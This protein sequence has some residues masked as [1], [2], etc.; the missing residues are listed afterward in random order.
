MTLDDQQL[1]LISGWLDGQLTEAE[2]AEFLR[3]RSDDTGFQKAVDEFT[4]IRSTLASLSKAN[5]SLVRPREI[6]NEQ[7]A[8]N[9]VGL[10][11]QRVAQ[12][13][14]APA[15]IEPKSEQTATS[16]EHEV[17]TMKTVARRQKHPVRLA[18]TAFLAIAASLLMISSLR[19]FIDLG[20]D[21]NLV[22]QSSGA[23]G[24]PA[25]KTNSDLQPLL[26]ENQNGGAMET[27]AEILDRVLSE[28]R[29]RSVPEYSVREQTPAV[30]TIAENSNSGMP[31][32]P[33]LPLVP[34]EDSVLNEEALLNLLDQDAPFL[35][36]AVDVSIDPIARENKEFENILAKH[37]IPFVTPTAI[38]QELQSVLV[39]S[40]FVAQSQPDDSMGEADEVVSLVFVKA[41]AAR[42]ENALRDIYQQYKD[43]PAFSLEM[44]FDPPAI[45]CLRKLEG[46][47]EAPIE[48]NFANY[49]RPS[50][51]SNLKQFI[52]V[53]RRI[54]PANRSDET[55]WQPE[56]IGDSKM[57]PVSSFLFIL[58]HTSGE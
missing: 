14:E 39:S 25:E 53:K 34:G 28:S 50:Q 20:A 31:T 9:I 21:L 46:I 4:E 47:R 8:A 44:C 1:D 58:R 37:D 40:R 18:L 6:S 11:R 7:F 5:E 38:T 56:G 45:E 48:G 33:E 41:R 23:I 22:G 36:M 35:L 43:F 17:T 15:W 19:W 30:E 55:T 29:D 3:L 26:V 42:I 13:E 57:N 49:L 32:S 12:S 27:G 16:T 2:R 24:S 54:P 52:G 51:D 10:A